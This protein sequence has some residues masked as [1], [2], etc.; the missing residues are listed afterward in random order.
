MARRASGIGPVNWVKGQSP[1]QTDLVFFSFFFLLGLIFSCFSSLLSF[2]LFFSGSPLLHFV[3]SSP[4][5]FWTEKNNQEL[6]RQGTTPAENGCRR[7]RRKLDF[8][9]VWAA[10]ALDR[11]RESWASFFFSFLSISCLFL[12]VCR[13]ERETGFVDLLGLMELG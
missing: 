9:M 10:A 5:L 13:L 8:E 4:L 3:S 2:S 12:F 1:S 7:R 6:Q 11:C